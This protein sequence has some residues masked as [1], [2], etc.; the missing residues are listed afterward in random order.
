[1][2]LYYIAGMLLFSSTISYT[3]SIDDSINQK[4]IEKIITY[5]ASDELG[6]R[7]NYTKKQLE[8]AEF[9]GN[10]FTQCGLVP[11]PGF[12][13]FYQGF[14][15]PGA[16]IDKEELTWNDRELAD[17]SFKFFPRSLYTGKKT[18]SD[19][20][21]LQAGYPVA[22]SV[23]FRNW[24]GKTDDILLWVKLPDSVSFSAGTA[25]IVVPPGMP[26]TDILIVA[27]PDEPQ[28]LK[29]SG[30]G[31]K[32][33]TTLYNVI[34]M[35][36]GNSKADEAIIFSAHYDHIDKDAT[37]KGG[38]IFNGANDDASGTTAVMALARYYAMRNDNERSI[39]FCLFAG[40]E[41]GLFGS[42]AFVSYIKPEAIKANINI[43]MIGATNVAGKKAFFV[44]GSYY[45]NLFKIL[46]KNL[47]GEKTK[48]MRHASDPKLLFQRSD[49]YTFALEGIPAHSI[50]CS[51]DSDPCYHKPCDEVKWIEMENMT[52][53]IQG[54]AKS[55]TSLISGEDT[56]KRIKL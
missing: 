22:D 26:S 35:L 28:A 36:P 15:Q 33:G 51:D 34:G 21:I 50:M 14:K 37:G 53:V 18:L 43:E 52:K 42:K 30:T 12:T 27:V 10:E 8:A 9:I 45:S 11:F 19:F 39:I 5:L 6:G 17:S 2:R 16:G 41:L 49:N 24:W 46:E 38:E 3:Q 31:K 13:N 1:M 29:F 56:P 7:V 25:N 23:L 48:V 4:H 55:C 40:E 32:I 54:I 20:F 44:T 47:K